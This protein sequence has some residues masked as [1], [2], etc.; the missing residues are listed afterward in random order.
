MSAVHVEKNRLVQ[1][2]CEIN[3]MPIIMCFWTNTIRCGLL[4]QYSFFID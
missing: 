1:N 4:T 3:W 2:P